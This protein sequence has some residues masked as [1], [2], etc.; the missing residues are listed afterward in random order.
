MSKKEPW[1][2]LL[3]W[4][5]LVLRFRFITSTTITTF[6]LFPLKEE[7]ETMDFP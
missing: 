4:K 6:R 2:D 5:R 1:W 3:F 7:N